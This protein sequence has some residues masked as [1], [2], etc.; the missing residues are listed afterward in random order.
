MRDNIEFLCKI[1][2]L[3]ILFG[4]CFIL[5]CLVWNEIKVVIYIF[6]GILKV[7]F[8]IILFCLEFGLVEV[9]SYYI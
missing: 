4:I 5:L 3:L 9:Y 7:M 8:E 1:G 2:L 6:N